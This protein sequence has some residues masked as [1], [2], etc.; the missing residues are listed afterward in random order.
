MSRETDLIFNN[1][2]KNILH[3]LHPL[4][5][6]FIEVNSTCNLNCKHCYIPEQLK[7]SVLPFTEIEKIVNLVSSEFGN[8]VGIAITGGEPLLHPDFRKVINILKEKSFNWSLATNGLLL[9]SKDIDILIKNNCTAITISLDGN[10]KTHEIQR[11]KKDIYKKVIDVIEM[12]I[13]KEFPAIYITATIHDD[14]VHSLDD[15]Y[16]LIKRYDGNLKWRINPLL[17]CENVE[18]NNLY[19]SKET[20]L[21]ICDFSKMVKKELGI[22]IIIGE[23]NPLSIKHNEYLY[24]Y[25][26]SCFAGI[27]TFGILA[28]GNVVNCMVCRENK[29]GNISEI[30]S[31]K[32]VWE[33]QDL[34]QKGLCKRHLESKNTLFK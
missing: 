25:F 30:N 12:L 23:K 31:L 34:R 5:T 6:L 26:D 33:K 32:N 17:Y 21:K 2:R 20:Y 14:N 19:I 10:E 29:L 3:T 18:R 1:L 28:N 7:Q 24:S 8:S 13:E 16:Q 15:M 22:N 9:T 4:Q 11:R 27:S